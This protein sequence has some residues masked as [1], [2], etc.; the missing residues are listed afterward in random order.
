MLSDKNIYRALIQ[1]K[2]RKIQERGIELCFIFLGFFLK[3]SLNYF[4][5][6]WNVVFKE[7][8]AEYKA[9]IMREGRHKTIYT[10]SSNKTRLVQSPCIFKEF[11]YNHIDYN[12][13]S[14]KQEISFAQTPSKK[15]SMLK[16]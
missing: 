7:F 5:S 9:K 6:C 14:N 13:S 3:S 12:C 8:A 15:L 2:V 11:H 10:G 16:H 1:L 4:R